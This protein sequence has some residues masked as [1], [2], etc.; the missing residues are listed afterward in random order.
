MSSISLSAAGSLLLAER[1]TKK[2]RMMNEKSSSSSSLS[3]SLSLSSVV[4]VGGPIED[5]DTAIQKLKNAGFDLEKYNND[6]NDEQNVPPAF[7]GYGISTW[8]VT[9]MIYFCGKG[10]LKMCRYLFVNGASCSKETSNRFWFPMYVAALE[11]QTD[12]CKW[13][14]EHG[15][16]DDIKKKNSWGYTPLRASV[17]T[18]LGTSTNHWLILNGALCQND[19][20]TIGDTIMKRDL[21]PHYRYKIVLWAQE[22][23]QFH[24]T[25]I[26]FLG[27]TI[28]TSSPVDSSP[29]QSF[30]GKSGIMELIGD[31]AG[32]VRGS[33]L[34]MLRQFVD[35]FS[36]FF[37]DVPK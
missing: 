25:F 4:D 27:G 15:A 34:R 18:D 35:R 32:V 31:Y 28:S 1:Q 37:E 13:L 6:I 16:K 36:A 24:N 3:S 11:S 23:V 8:V 33:K 7:I 14:Y 21:D 9:P 5:T 29:L 22:T 30:N 20:S 19:S 10:D 26:I 2:R 17:K 12:V